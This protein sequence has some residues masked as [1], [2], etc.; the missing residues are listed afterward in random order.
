MLLIPLCHGRV[1]VHVL[2]DV[3]P[4]DTRVVSTEGNLTFLSTVGNDTHLGASEIVVEE[5]LEPHSGDEEEV[6]TIG[7]TLIDVLY[8]AVATDLTVILT[9]QAKRL[10][11]LLKELVKRKLRGRLVR[12]VV[13]QQR[14]THHQVRHPLATRS[15]RNLLHVLYET[16]N[17]QELRNRTHLF[18]FF[19]DHHRCTYATV[20]VTSARYLSPFSLW[21]V[22]KVGKVGKGAH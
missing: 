19:I 8:T 2:D 13:F 21:P 10:V 3:S 17:I 16:R 20:R 12:V 4:A 1:L 11:K 7:T 5:I 14:Q 6:P 18:V 22:N 9:S 15:V